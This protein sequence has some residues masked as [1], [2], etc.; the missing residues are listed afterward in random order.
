M[1]NLWI[2][3]PTKYTKLNVQ[4]IKLI[5]STSSRAA[6][7]I[8]MMTLTEQTPLEDGTQVA[9]AVSY[10]E[11]KLLRCQ[12]TDLSRWRQETGRL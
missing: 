4:Q 5:N 2:V 9:L 1:L 10:Q 7:L 6:L 8:R 3:L 11:V 12:V